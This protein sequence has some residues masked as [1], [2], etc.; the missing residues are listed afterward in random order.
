MFLIVLGIG[1][2]TAGF[3]GLLAAQPIADAL[4]AGLAVIMWKA[5]FRRESSVQG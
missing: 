2:L 5:A 1:V 4:S 3:T